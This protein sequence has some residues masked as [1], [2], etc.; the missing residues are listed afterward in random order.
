[1]NYHAAPLPL[2]EELSELR[3]LRPAEL[4]GLK[5]TEGLAEIV[6]LAF[7]LMEANSVGHP[8][9][10]SQ[11]ARSRAG[12]MINDASETLGP[13]TTPIAKSLM[14]GSRLARRFAPLGRDDSAALPLP[15]RAGI[16]PPCRASS[17]FFCLSSPAT[18]ALAQATQGGRP[19]YESDLQRLSEILGALH[20]LRDICGARE[21]QA[22]RNEMQALV[23]AEAPSGERRERLVASFN[24]G[25]RG[26]QQSYRTCTP[27]ADFAIRRYLEE[28][29]KI[30]R[31]ITARYAN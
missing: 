2:L 23:D 31:D 16:S 5:T 11:R 26:F 14:H 6:E 22:W 20:Y 24:R 15:H 7:R 3:W 29:A 18:P 10:P 21:G 9:R 27:A 28:G 30:A 4:S 25:Y 19:A 17:P 12:P 1:M 8:G 13:I